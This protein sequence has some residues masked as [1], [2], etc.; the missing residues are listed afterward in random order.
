MAVTPKLD[1][2]PKFAIL[3]TQDLTDSRFIR[4]FLILSKRKSFKEIFHTIYF[5]NSFFPLK[6]LHS[7]DKFLFFN[8][9]YSHIYKFH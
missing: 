1:S 6:Q 3:L 4:F 7:C 2:F 9:S 5:D 8:S